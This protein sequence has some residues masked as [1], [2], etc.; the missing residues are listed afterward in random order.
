[1]TAYTVAYGGRYTPTRSKQMDVNLNPTWTTTTLSLNDTYTFCFIPAGAML[2]GLGGVFPDMD[3]NGSPLLTW[4][5][6]DSASATRFLSAS[7]I[8]QFAGSVLATGTPYYYSADDNLV[9]K[10]HAASATAV[11]GLIRMWVAYVLDGVV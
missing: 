10:V 4:D 3:T 6:G 2:V 11:Q 7:T 8:G 1:M 5:L 9:L